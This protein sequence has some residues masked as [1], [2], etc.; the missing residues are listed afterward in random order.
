MDLILKEM[1][2]SVLRGEVNDD[3]FTSLLMESGMNL[4]DIEWRIAT[5][6]LGEYDRINYLACNHV[7]PAFYQ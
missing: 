6:L 2:L 3:K 1:C 4:E 7:A 5:K